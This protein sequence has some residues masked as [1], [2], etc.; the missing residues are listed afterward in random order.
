MTL[1][2]GEALSSGPVLAADS[3]LTFEHGNTSD[4]LGGALKVV[5]VDPHA[6]IAFSGKAALAVSAIRTAASSDPGDRRA[7]LAAA[8]ADADVHFLLAEIGSETIT[9][10]TDGTTIE[11]SAVRAWIGD[12][13]AFSRFQKLA[14]EAPPINAPPGLDSLVERAQL[15]NAMRQL[16]DEGHPTV[17]GVATFVISE[18]GG[19]RYS[20][21]VEAVAGGRQVIPPDRWTTVQFGQGAA[22]GSYTETILTPSGSGVG[23]VGVHLSEAHAGALF[24]PLRFDQP[25][26]YRDVGVEQMISSIQSDHGLSLDGPRLG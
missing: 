14:A 19:F 25:V 23:A 24:W 21:A 8:S 1:V 20:C 10:I 11:H 18:P 17:G 15:M 5:I 7:I 22:A 26:Q 13:Q 2:V 3:M 9:R 6:A 16:V 12:R 4:L